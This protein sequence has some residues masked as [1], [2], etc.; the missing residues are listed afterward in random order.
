MTY[1]QGLTDKELK[2]FSDLMVKANLD[3]IIFMS[4]ETDKEVSRRFD[5]I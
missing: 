2:Q 5:Q 3:Q 4:H 1:K